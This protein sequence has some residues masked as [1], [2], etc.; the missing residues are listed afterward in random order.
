VLEVSSSNTGGQVSQLRVDPTTGKVYS[1][2][3]K[4]GGVDLEAARGTAKTV[5]SNLDT[6]EKN[7]TQIVVQ[8]K[9]G[10]GVQTAKVVDD[11]LLFTLTDGSIIDAGVVEGGGGT[12][13]ADPVEIP[14]AATDTASLITLMNAIR[15]VLID[16]Q[17]AKPF[18]PS[19][20]NPNP[21]PSTKH[22]GSLNLS[23]GNILSIAVL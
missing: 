20:P 15:Q 5:D 21:N 2:S 10:R 16:N 13:P 4:V 8:G 23:Y 1:S 14:D 22:L 12:A 18:Q 6:V 17:F 9:E 19:N 3:S 7:Y 11:R